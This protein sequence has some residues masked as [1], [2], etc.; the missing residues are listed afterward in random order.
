MVVAGCSFAARGLGAAADRPA[1][2][3]RHSVSNLRHTCGPR[4]PLRRDSWLDPAPTGQV[5]VCSGEP[6]VPTWGRT[7]PEAERRSPGPFVEG[8]SGLGCSGARASAA[9]CCCG[10]QR[11]V[12][13]LAP[14]FGR[15]AFPALPAATPPPCAR[16]G[17][18]FPCGSACPILPGAGSCWFSFPP[19]GQRAL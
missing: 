14:A 3:V 8:C 18:P 16:R 13:L 6:A 17:C 12:T 10:R 4:R 2:H 1:H 11:S 9:G 5:R 15:R 7:G 19:S